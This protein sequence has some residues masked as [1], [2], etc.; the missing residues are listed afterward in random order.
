MMMDLTFSENFN[1]SECF[2]D[3]KEHLDKNS[4]KIDGGEGTL[5]AISL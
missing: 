1:I 5:V 3:L 2:T 4:E